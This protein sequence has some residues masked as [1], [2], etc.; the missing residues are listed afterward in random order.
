VAIALADC[1]SKANRP[2]DARRLYEQLKDSPNAKSIVW[3]NL[4]V[5]RAQAGDTAG[6]E[7]AYR[8]TLELSPNDLDAM[9]NLGLILFK[10][11]EYAD[12]ETLFD[13]LSGL[14]PISTEAKSNLAAAAAKAGDM[15]KAIAVWK[16]L[17]HAEPW[18]VDVR[19]NLAN[20]LWQTGDAEAA[21]AG[22]LQ[23]LSI[24]KHNAEG[25]NGVGLYDLKMGKLAPAENAFRSAILANANY[26]PAYNNLAVVLEK[27]N[28]RAD[29][30]RILERASEIAP[31][32]AEV[33]KNLERMKAAD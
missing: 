7:E 5:L 24:D 14:N 9:N 6:A 19:L 22:Y 2:A 27:R 29:A 1:Y 20:A 3:F 23:V 12:A 18:R 17:A 31:D 10:K 16:Q 30:I 15:K 8:K 25:F 26:V 4:G 11:G 13:K 33:R 28:K 21:R 32:N